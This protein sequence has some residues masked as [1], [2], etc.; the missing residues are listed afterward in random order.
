[1]RSSEATSCDPSTAYKTNLQLDAGSFYSSTPHMVNN[2]PVNLPSPHPED[3]R[4]AVV[5]RVFLPDILSSSTMAGIIR[6]ILFSI[7]SITV[8]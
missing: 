2:L 4:Q 1:M 8:I 6:L 5:V 7:F 3:R